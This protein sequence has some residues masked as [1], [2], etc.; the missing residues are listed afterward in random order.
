MNSNHTISDQKG[1]HVINLLE[2]RLRHVKY[3]RSP[4]PNN[5]VWERINV[6]V[7]LH[8]GTNA[9][10]RMQ[11]IRNTTNS[12]KNNKTLF[13]LLLRWE[14]STSPRPR[15]H[16]PPPHRGRARRTPWATTWVVNR[17]I[18]SSFVHEIWSRF[19][20]AVPISTN[21]KQNFMFSVQ[22]QIWNA[23]TNEFQTGKR[24]ST[25]AR[26]WSKF[27][28]QNKNAT[29]FHA[30]MMEK[31]FCLVYYSG[32]NGGRRVWQAPSSPP[33]PPHDKHTEI[34]NG[35][36]DVTTSGWQMWTWSYRGK[37]KG[38]GRKEWR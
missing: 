31:W 37:E 38:C 36:K 10:K 29:K 35:T 1:I 8:T 28:G 20:F 25:F 12:I 6:A 23:E 9:K 11:I 18:V 2:I 14:R 3:T 27:E 16:T 24:T 17:I 33:S 22:I 21:I 15:R 30:K 7:N 34:Q 32:G 26:Y 19:H 13:C 4:G 5:T